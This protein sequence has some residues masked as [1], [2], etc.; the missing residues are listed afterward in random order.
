MKKTESRVCKLENHHSTICQVYKERDLT[1]ELGLEHF[2]RKVEAAHCGA[3]DLFIPMQNQL[4]QSHLKSADHN[5]NRKAMMEQSKKEGLCVARSILNHKDIGQ[6]FES[7]LKGENPFINN[8]DEADDSIAME[9]SATEVKAEAGAE[10]RDGE[11]AKTTP[12][13]GLIPSDVLEEAPLNLDPEAVQAEEQDTQEPPE[14]SQDFQPE[15]EGFEM[16]DEDYVAHDEHVL[17]G[18]DI[19]EGLAVEEPAE[20]Q[21]DWPTEEPIEE[22][23]EEAATESE[24]A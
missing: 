21:A 23:A 8:P 13:E 19:G 7:F 4:I 24:Q 15:E 6:K 1:R 20:D 16:G 5:Y 18:A 9:V 17:E 14:V 22:A 3:C 10:A 11:L 12:L 2:I